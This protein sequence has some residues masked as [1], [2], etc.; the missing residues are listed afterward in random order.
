MAKRKEAIK[1]KVIPKKVRF[2]VFKRDSFTC[3][4][5]GRKAPNVLLVIDHIEPVSKGGTDD[6]LNLISACK[7]C[8][9]GKSARKLSDT[10]VLD[11]QRQQLEGLQE[12]KEQIEMMFKWQEGLLKLNDQVINQLAD[13]WSEQVPGYRLNENGLKGLKK[14]KRKFE[15]DEIMDAMKIAA[16]QYLDYEDGVPTEDSVGQAWKKV[17]G[18]CNVKRQEEEKPYIKRLFYIRGILRN[19]LYYVDE[20]L[21]LKLLQ[22]AVEADASIDSLEEH[23][24][25]VRNWTQWRGEI[26][27]FIFSKTNAMKKMNLR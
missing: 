27:D 4:Y 10:S 8:N 15:I 21:V 11:K 16:E 12:R 26:E 5:C 13:Y 19:R 2:E 14:L 6:I 17:G 1:R 3:Q 7:D 24:K 9:A 18:I 20:K 25:S 22:K 23:A